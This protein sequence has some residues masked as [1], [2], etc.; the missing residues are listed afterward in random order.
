MIAGLALF[1]DDEASPPSVA[2]QSAALDV[3]AETAPAATGGGA[4]EVTG[5]KPSKNTELV[6]G[7]SYSL[8]LPAGWTRVPA[9]G[10]A[11]LAAVAPE[12]AADA[13]LWVEEDA[14][15]DFPNFISQSLAQL[16]ALTGSARIV[17]RIPAPTPE[18]TVVRLAA[19][20]PPDQPSYEVTLRVAGPYRYYLATSVQPGAAPAAIKD[21]E[22]VV[23]SLTPEVGG[24]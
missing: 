18:A 11:T 7:S 17:A 16:E 2:V 24:S 13:T 1:Q 20:T 22:L 15:L 21:T 3:P 8:A 4:T 14:K 5:A 23:G 12:G 10:G 6:R 9:S 19:D